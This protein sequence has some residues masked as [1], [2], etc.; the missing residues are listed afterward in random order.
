MTNSSLKYSPCASLSKVFSL[1]GERERFI[2]TFTTQNNNQTF[3]NTNKKSNTGTNK[4]ST[5]IRSKRS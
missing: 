1:N 2:L 3:H 4:Q 5:L